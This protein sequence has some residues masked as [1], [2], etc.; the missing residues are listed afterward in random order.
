MREMAGKKKQ[1][2]SDFDTLSPKQIKD[3]L[4]EAFSVLLVHPDSAV[5]RTVLV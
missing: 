3:V 2:S 5:N 1:K 4:S